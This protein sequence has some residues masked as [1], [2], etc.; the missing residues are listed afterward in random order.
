MKNKASM[1]VA[2]AS[3]AINDACCRIVAFRGYSD[4]PSHKS[5]VAVTNAGIRAISEFDSIPVA[6]RINRRLDCWGIAG[7]IGFYVPGISE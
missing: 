7:T 6:R 2:V 3:L 5:D 1:P 4:C